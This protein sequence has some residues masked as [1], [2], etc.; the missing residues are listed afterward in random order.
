M[1]YCY[2]DRNGAKLYGQYSKIMT[3]FVAQLTL[4]LDQFEAHQS[5]AILNEF[6]KCFHDFARFSN[7]SNKIFDYLVKHFDV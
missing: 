4:K 7:Y 1:E 6:I 3:D 2:D 5:E